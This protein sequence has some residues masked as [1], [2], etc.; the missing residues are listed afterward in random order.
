MDAAGVGVAMVSQ[1]KQWSCERQWLC[2]DARLE[3][4][5]RFTAASSRFA[6]LAGYNP[7]DAAE[8]LREMEAA[9]AMGFRG[10]Y[11]HAASFG[12]RLGDARLYPLW[13][14]SA[15]LGLPAVVQVA[16]GEP[17]LPL[18][19]ERI[20]RDFP[21]LQ[22]AIVHPRPTMELFEVACPPAASGVQLAFVLDTDALSWMQRQGPDLLRP[23]VAERCMWGSN[24]A[25]LAESVARASEL[26]VPA[27]TI[28][29]ILRGNAMRYFAAGTS[30]PAAAVGN[31]LTLAE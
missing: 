31:E 20:G 18:C 21:E 1:C 12:V 30:R 28:E 13:A 9:G 10:T 17:A 27:A 29:A 15:E 7:F 24:G 11:L 5:A 3:D 23:Y 19:L 22:L 2:V 4:V 6:G 25:P 16:L 8:S 26:E 14:K